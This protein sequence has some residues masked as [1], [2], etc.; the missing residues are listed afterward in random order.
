MAVVWSAVLGLALV[1][2]LAA[3]EAVPASPIKVTLH[4]RALSA[5]QLENTR[6]AVQERYVR[7]NL[8]G[9]SEE[10]IPLLDF[11]DAQCKGLAGE[12]LV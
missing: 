4:K 9:S 1:A 10:D 7:S 11:L 8:L 3:G 12:K 5:K 6:Q 2:G